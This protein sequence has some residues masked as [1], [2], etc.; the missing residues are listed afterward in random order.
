MILAFWLYTFAL[1]AVG[2]VVYRSLGVPATLLWFLW[3]AVSALVWMQLAWH[4][5]RTDGY[6]VEKYDAKDGH[7]RWRVGVRETN[8]TTNW[9]TPGRTT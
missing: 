8:G 4:D 1:C 2:S 7:R 5:V 9:T 3:N 6:V